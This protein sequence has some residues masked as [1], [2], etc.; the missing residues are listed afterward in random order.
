MTNEPK[1]AI[2]HSS[3]NVAGGGE[4]VALAFIKVLKSM[5][6]RVH[7]ITAEP[8][9]WNKL[10]R[11]VGDWI[12]RPD[13]E[14]PLLPFEVKYFGIYT[15][16]LSGVKLLLSKKK[17]DLTINTHGDLMPVETDI[18]YMHFPTFAIIFETAANVKYK[19]SL[20]W[21]TY[22]E[23]FRLI[24]L[25]LAKRLKSSSHSIILTNSEYSRDAI[26]KHLGKNAIVL[27]PPVDIEDFLAAGSTAPDFREDIV[28]ACGR[29]TP[30]KRYEFILE[31]ASHLKDIG[32]KI[33]G[34]R[35]GKVTDP[36]LSKLKNII[37]ARRL[38]NVELLVDY[39][40]KAQL[41]LY[42]KAKVFM[43]S[44]V[45]EHFGIAVVEGM[46]AGLVPV[47]HKSGGPWNDI[48][49]MGKY[50]FGY[51]SLDSAIEAVTKAIREHARLHKLVIERAR[52]FS[53][54]SFEKKVEV[55]IDKVL[56]EL[57]R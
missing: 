32:F 19:E 23:P 6:F 38:D 28:V 45:G 7:L 3:L 21:R 33:V 47:V 25:M 36:Y 20:F 27:P 43:H 8:T 2:V 14:T 11:L 10:Y 52:A 5:G 39:P 48:I 13:E 42:S 40:R 57:K 9:N 24:Q 35:S 18:V 46:A 15:R 26:K 29:F 53:R 1:A 34:A 49:Y 30:E 16:I 31:V 4:R 56:E 22:F 50:G 51:D 54:K 12:E 37:E 17:Y 55:I 41:K 44:M